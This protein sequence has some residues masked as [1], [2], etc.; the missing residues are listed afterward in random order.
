MYLSDVRDYIA[1]LGLTKDEHCYMS[2]LDSKPKQAIGCY[3]L[4]RQGN[5]PKTIGGQKSYG[6]Y[7]VSLLIH[8]NESPRQ[9]EAVAKELYDCLS[10]LS[11]TTI[12]NIKLKFTRL[13]TD[14]PVDVGKD[15]NGI[16]EW[17]I[18]V[19]FYYERR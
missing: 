6:V 3:R 15:D 5:S 16:C 14:Y 8:W 9:S 18:E 17:V 12:N 13:L 2:T 4:N 11:D 1:S 10:D 7:P 19:E